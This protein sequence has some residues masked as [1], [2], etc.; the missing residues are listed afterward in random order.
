MD[1]RKKYDLHHL[2]EILTEF[3]SQFAH[4][5]EC[6]RGIRT[7]GEL[8]SII[9]AGMGGSAMPAELLQGY[10][11]EL[12]LPLHAH[13]TYGLPAFANEKTML[14]AVS[15]SGNTEEPVDAFKTALQ[16]KC[17]IVA[18][19]SGGKL[20][21]LALENNV[22]L[23][24]I[25]QGLQPRHAL[26]LQFA[27]CLGVLQN[28]GLCGIHSQEV[29]E[30]AKKL[31]KL[32]DAN[33]AKANAKKIRNVTP[34]VYSSVN[35]YPIARICRIAF[36]ENTKIQ[37]FSSEVPEM[38]HNELAGF[39]NYVGKYSA[40]LMHDEHDH[41]R[42]KKR[43]KVMKQLMEKRKVK[44]MDY[45]MKGSNYFEKAFSSILHFSWLS[46]WLA[47]EYKQDPTPV[48]MVEEFKHLLE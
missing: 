16:R 23:V 6:A 19:A 15:Y 24:R 47:L 48:L 9:L 28:S 7:G 11:K 32:C 42:I 38:N 1:L 29:M 4:G 27:A 31:G 5:L 20:A 13:R 33:R 25:P 8:E 17:K 21:E 34:L 39:Q 35:N 40:F 18:V 22:P 10:L 45:E 43:M 3:P 41:P 37:A 46:Y 2:Y 30:S 14:I 26:G 12:S 44:C 36:N